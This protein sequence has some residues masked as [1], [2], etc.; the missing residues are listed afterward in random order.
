MAEFLLTNSR[1]DFSSLNGDEN[2]SRRSSK[3]FGENSYKL[4]YNAVDK[5]FMD[6]FTQADT[7][8]AVY[9]N[10]IT[11]VGKFRID[12]YPNQ[13]LSKWQKQEDGVLDSFSGYGNLLIWNNELYE[14]TIITSRMGF[15][16]VYAGEVSKSGNIVLG[17]HP[18]KIAS[19][20]KTKQLNKVSVAEFIATGNITPPFTYYE[21]I[22][23]LEPASVYR[24]NKNGLH[25]VKNYWKPNLDHD[26]FFSSDESARYLA[27]IIRTT[28]NQAFDESDSK[29]LLLLSGGMDS[30]AVLFSADNPS[31]VLK[32]ATFYTEENIELKKAAQLASIAG[33]E[34]YPLKREY[35]Y[36]ANLAIDAV[37]LTGGMWNFACCHTYGFRNELRR[38]NPG[39]MLSG[40]CFDTLFRGSVFQKK[41][42]Y[43]KFSG[44]IKKEFADQDIYW[45]K[46]GIVQLKD[47][48]KEKIHNRRRDYYG[49]DTIHSKSLTPIMLNKIKYSRLKN[50]SRLRSSGIENVLC[51]TQNY[52]L[53]SSGLKI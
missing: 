15:F 44:T 21:D 22:F 27:E 50:L 30:R 32:A 20:L 19:I 29:G 43:N 31:A 46:K 34:H 28:V 25:F 49:F 53:V 26:N 17:N 6:P 39:V 48:W 33:V 5:S 41:E 12:K 13:F 35:D 14:W 38:I 45:D 8:N 16:P 3:K 40:I 42:S 9:C 4:C 11:R 47:K 36:Y 24:F 51:K 2:E 1:S 7:G 18:D 52:D 23:Q 37:K 10:G